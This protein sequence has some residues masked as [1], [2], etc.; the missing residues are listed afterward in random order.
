MKKK[1]KVRESKENHTK[2]WKEETGRKFG[3]AFI[4]TFVSA[5]ASFPDFQSS[6]LLPCLAKPPLFTV[7]VLNQAAEI[8]GKLG[9]KA[10]KFAKKNLQ[11]V[12]RQKRKLNSKSMFKKKKT[13]R[14]ANDG[15]KDQAG[16]TTSTGREPVIE[17][18]VDASLD[19]FS[20]EEEDD[21][22]EDGS[23]SDGFLSEDS[24]CS[25]IGGSETELHSEDASQGSELSVQNK[26]ISAEL[27]EKKKRV[28]A[29]KLKDPDFVIFLQER[30]KGLE[31]LDN[32][33][34]SDEDESSNHDLQSSTGITPSPNAG[35]LLSTSTVKSWCQIVKEQQNLSVLRGLLNAY[36]AA[37]HYGTESTNSKA[38]IH[39]PI[40][41]SKETFCSILMF[42]LSEGDNLIRGLLGIS[43]NCK[44]QNILDLKNSSKWES[45]KPMVKSYLTST[46]FLLNQFTDVDILAYSL[47]RLR[48]SL[49]FFAAFPSLQKKLIEVAVHL[50]ATGGG[51]L[52]SCSFFVLHDL[53]SLFGHNSYDICL[54]KTYKAIISRCKVVD[55]KSLKHIEYIKNSFVELC[56][57]DL[58][59]SVKLA[60]ASAQKLAMILKLGLQNKEEALK[61]ICSWE[62]VLCIDLWVKF[63]SVNIKDNDLHGLLYPLIQVINGVAQLYAGPRYLPLKVKCIKWLNQLSAS[64]GIFIPVSSMALDIL[65][66]CHVLEVGKTVKG[67][68]NLST[69]L[70]LP[71]FWLKSRDF[72]EECVFA[73]VELLCAH[74]IQ[75]SHHISFP[76]LA[77][78]PVIRLKHFYEKSTIESLRRSVQRLIDQVEKNVDFVERKREGVSFSPI[79]QASADSFLQGEKRNDNSPFIQYY[80]SIMQNGLTRKLSTDNQTS[81]L[82][83]KKLNGRKRK[84]PQKTEDVNANADKEIAKISSNVS[85]RS[86]Q[87]VKRK[88][89]RT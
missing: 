54:K 86:E 58:Q 47:T 33:D 16:D 1:E 89:Q 69:M 42:M 30:V 84:L 10:R 77:T 56:S 49:V 46:L 19:I 50:W 9:K 32:E 51:T 80:T 66:S 75:W 11:S 20:S 5:A 29:L 63:I 44:K 39:A 8:M 81:V 21:V 38:S 76:E 27:L 34:M 6:T 62:Y 23:D 73:A 25:Y 36:R 59:K 87:V 18:I 41:Q 72:Q 48:V 40:I 53:A 57:I 67:D 31:S 64:S 65:E 2:T 28:E 88:K 7:F 60:L 85:T 82:K 68:V 70:Q 4:L 71:K 15:L 13:S 45:V 43:S 35:R 74:F 24:S 17:D 14:G 22:F 37:C 79:D 3:Q 83:L 26:I 52:S 61:K 78:V 55:P 12:M